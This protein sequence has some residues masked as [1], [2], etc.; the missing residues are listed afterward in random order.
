MKTYQSFKK[1]TAARITGYA[2]LDPVA[3]FPETRPLELTLDDGSQVHV[4]GPRFDRV[5]IGGYYVRADDGH[6]FY[7]PAERFENSYLELGAAPDPLDDETDR[8]K[9]VAGL[10]ADGRA[11][12]QVRVF[13][14]H[15]DLK[16][17]AE[18]LNKF[19][20]TPMYSNLPVE[21][22]QRMRAQLIAMYAYADILAERIAAF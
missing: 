22:K 3:T 21:E 16:E 19:F 1:V 7:C 18:K 15:W 13:E 9:A 10:I 4:I 14:E 12:H 5:E 8:A 20:S 6:D 17:R 2:Y 11:P